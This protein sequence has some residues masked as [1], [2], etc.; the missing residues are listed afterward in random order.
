[1]KTR[2]PL[3]ALFALGAFADVGPDYR[4]PA[5]L[6]AGEVP[7]HFGETNLWQPAQPRADRARGSWWEQ[8]DDAELNRLETAAAAANQML[9][10][11]AR[12]AQARATV[13]VARAGYF[14]HLEAAPSY[15]R[16]RD[17][18]N[19]P[20]N[21][22]FAGYTETYN[23]FVVPLDLGWEADLWGRV[24]REVESA[25]A[26]AQ[27]GAADLESVR[28]ALH[29]E[30]AADYFTL[31]AL[32]DELALLRG[33]AAAQTKAL[34]LTRNRRRGGVTTDLDVA[35]AET[36]LR[37]TESQIPA[38]QLQRTK[39]EHALAV[40]TGANPSAFRLEP[41]TNCS[42]HAATLELST[43]L[44]GELLE[45]RP[46]VAAAERRVAAANADIGVAK[47]AFYPSFKFSAAAGLQSI[48]ASSL[49]DWPSRLWAFGPSL[50]LPL[51]E[52]G[53]NRAGL[54][55]ARAAWDEAVANYRQTVLGAFQEVED[56][57]A[58]RRLLSAQLE[59]AQAALTAARRALEIS[60]NRYRGGLVTFLDV[61]SAQQSALDRERTVAQLRGEQAV[62]T[63]ALIKALGGGWDAERIAVATKR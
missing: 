60:L 11:A 5:A 52:G 51:F 25:R 2:L 36:Q 34:E 23:N 57:L 38:V 27:A 61:A 22:R 4:R 7:A 55:R 18:V 8:F 17:S 1:M 50:S 12:F 45:R 53:R 20:L 58:A 48:G 49:F 14:P 24:R 35:Q 6:P 13:N 41:V 29:A 33:T 40:L 59:A 47:G 32:D 63:V 19:R 39:L 26:H 3:A 30:V 10:A 46:D 28:L 37:T 62:A 16:S 9:A 56:Q 43:G 42:P 31:R 21:G 44:P 54:A 15:T